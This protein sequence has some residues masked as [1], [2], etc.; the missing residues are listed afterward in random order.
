VPLEPILGRV[1]TQTVSESFDPQ[2]WDVVPDTDLPDF[3]DITYHRCT[4][5]GPAGATVRIAFNRPEVLKFVVKLTD[6]GLIGQPDWSPC[7]SYY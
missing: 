2:S 1:P 3:T 6:D 4:L 5:D 7:P